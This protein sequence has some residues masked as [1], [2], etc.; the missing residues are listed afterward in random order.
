M[1]AWILLAESCQLRGQYDQCYPMRG[2]LLKQAG[3]AL[4]CGQVQVLRSQNV[5]DQRSLPSEG[6]IPVVSIWGSIGRAGPG[7]NIRPCGRR[8]EVGAGNLPSLPLGPVMCVQ[9][10][11]WGRTR[12]RVLYESVFLHPE[13]AR[14]Y[15]SRLYVFCLGA[16]ILCLAQMWFVLQSAKADFGFGRAGRRTPVSF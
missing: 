8:L 3:L 12:R 4:A 6:L 1:G 5:G 13:A 10:V 15:A 11:S 16:V 9:C 7:N 2:L 14:L